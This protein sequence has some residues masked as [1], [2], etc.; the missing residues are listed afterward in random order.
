MTTPS[1]PADRFKTRL[2]KTDHVFT[3]SVA[4][5]TERGPQ[6]PWAPGTRALPPHPAPAVEVTVCGFW[7]EVREDT[8]ALPCHVWGHLLWKGQ[9][10]PAAL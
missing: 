8:V 7:S 1:S 5:T 4:A 6:R 3:S 2:T 9:P 10:Q